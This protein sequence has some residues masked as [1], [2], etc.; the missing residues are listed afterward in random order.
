MDDFKVGRR[1]SVSETCA[2]P[3]EKVPFGGPFLTHLSKF[4]VFMHINNQV[5]II[6]NE[7]NKNMALMN[8]ACWITSNV[9][10]INV[11]LLYECLSRCLLFCIENMLLKLSGWQ[12]A[13]KLSTIYV[14]KNM[15]LSVALLAAQN[16]YVK[17]KL[18]HSEQGIFKS[19]T[20]KI[21]NYEK[22]VDGC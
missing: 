6:L 15:H 19:N 10:L 20:H 9:I 13:F 14:H 16:E 5:A 18:R 8:G 11:I 2:G 3:C 22:L 17:F 21:C 7:R 12:R 1:S 4:Y